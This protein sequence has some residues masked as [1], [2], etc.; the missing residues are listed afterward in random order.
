MVRKC[1]LRLHESEIF[2]VNEIFL[3]KVFVFVDDSVAGG[4]NSQVV[5]SAYLFALREG[6]SSRRM[7]F[8][9]EIKRL[10]KNPTAV[11]RL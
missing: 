9:Y 8:W 5:S 1:D 6:I 4:R 10:H 11:R 3:G 7:Y 2:Y